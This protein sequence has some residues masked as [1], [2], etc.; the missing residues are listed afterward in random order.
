MYFYSI[1][2]L[3]GT[4]S[5]DVGGLLGET[6]FLDAINLADQSEK[7]YRHTLLH[8]SHDNRRIYG[9]TP[10]NFVELPGYSYYNSNSNTYFLKKYPEE[11]RV[12]SCCDWWLNRALQGKEQG[13]KLEYI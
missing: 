4:E 3:L 9:C 7:L 8:G 1:N 10:F 12:Q 5:D 6:G 13:E 11:M 2:R